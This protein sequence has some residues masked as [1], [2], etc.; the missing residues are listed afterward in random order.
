MERI[1]MSNYSLYVNDNVKAEL[2]LLTKEE[3]N[4]INA[5]IRILIAKAIA[6]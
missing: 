2:M 1:N 5:K 3:R 4:S 6:Q